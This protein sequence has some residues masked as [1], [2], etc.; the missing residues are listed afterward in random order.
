MTSHGSAPHARPAE[1]TSGTG[2]I[3]GLLL[4]LLVSVVSGSC[5]SLQSRLNGALGH[6]MGDPYLAALVSFGSGL[7]VLVLGSVV[8]PAGRRGAVRACGLLRTGGIPWW[9]LAAGVFGAFLVIAQTVATVVLGVSVFILGLVVGQSLGGLLV[10][11]W[12]IGPGGVKHFTG[13]RIAGTVLIVVAVGLAMLPRFSSAHLGVP[14]PVLALT[15]LMPVLAGVL[16]T[17]QTAWNAGIAAGTGTP[18]TSTLTNFGSGT[19]ALLIT[20][21]ITRAAGPAAA[22]H[23]PS[24][25]WL[26]LGGMLGIVFVSAAAVLA[27]YFGVLLTSLGLVTGMLLGALVLDVVVPTPASVVTPVTVTGTLATLA[28]LVVVTLPWRGLPGVRAP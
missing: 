10:D 19:V 25:W 1:S 14:G 15:V 28:G 21:L 8:L 13:Y 12:G 6:E 27:R 5:L 18:I 9:Y 16:N 26:Y 2:H 3:T 7:V 4:G 20:L 22:P 23:W 17:V 11:R 24:E